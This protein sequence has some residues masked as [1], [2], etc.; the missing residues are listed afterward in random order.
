MP[1]LKAYL[2]KENLKQMICKII[3]HKWK[4]PKAYIYKQKNSNFKKCNRCGATKC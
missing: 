3:G 4:H 1:T 2:T